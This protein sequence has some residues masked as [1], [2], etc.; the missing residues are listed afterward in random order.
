M[1]NWSLF[2][3]IFYNIIFVLNS[4]LAADFLDQISALCKL[5]DHLNHSRT[6]NQKPPSRSECLDA[7]N[8]LLKGSFSL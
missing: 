7:A 8:Q 4:K 1:Q 5:S 3:V 2:T 6:Q